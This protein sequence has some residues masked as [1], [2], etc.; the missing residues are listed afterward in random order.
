MNGD[1]C[2]VLFDDL[3]GQEHVCRTSKVKS[4]LGGWDGSMSCTQEADKDDDFE[5]VNTHVLSYF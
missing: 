5:E 2:S 4:V 3:P 1:K